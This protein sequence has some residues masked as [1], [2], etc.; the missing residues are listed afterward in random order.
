MKK[1]Y[2]VNTITGELVRTSQALFNPKGK[3]WK[4]VTAKEFKL[5][6]SVANYAMSGWYNVNK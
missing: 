1:G 2:F 5:L 3:G 4:S 6:E